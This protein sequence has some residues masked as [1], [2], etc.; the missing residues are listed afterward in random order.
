[1]D[2]KALFK[3][4]IL[5]FQETPLPE[6]VPRDLAVPQDSQKVITVYGPRRAG[7]TFFMYGLIDRLTQRVEKS[8]IIYFNLE[9]ERLLPLDV[10]EMHLLIDAYFEL[11]P[12]HREGPVYLF[13]DE[14]Q[15]V[16]GWEVFIRRLH[17]SRR[18]RIFLTGSS[19]NLLSREIAT[20]LRGRT[21]AYQLTP[22]SF[23]EYLRF[24]EIPFDPKTIRY[25]ENRFS[26]IRALEDYLEWGGYPE[27][28][29]SDD[30]IALDILQN[31]FEMIVYR[32]IADRFSL[33]NSATL[34]NLL[35]Y[36]LTNVS[37][38]F[39]VNRY[40]GSLEPGMG[41][42]RETIQEYLS[43]ILETDII[44]LVPRFTFSLK[45]QEKNP[46]KVYAIDNGLR[47]ATAFVFSQDVGRLAENLVFQEL[48]RSGF[49]IYYWK[50]KQEV[51]FIARRRNETWAVNVSYGDEI[52]AREI[53][54]FQDLTASNIKPDRRLLIT[55]HAEGAE[56]NVEMAPLW[57]WL[58]EKK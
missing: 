51:D 38:L 13:L 54:G 42:A 53:T 55:K 19:A 37:N 10:K 2:K 36:L 3:R 56:G 6:M 5:E 49:E 18:F 12:E 44:A 14:I 43:C 58:I 33:R 30:E 11:F 26:V 20:S 52:P 48:S 7:K 28:V 27:V 50:G 39:S 25:S 40:Q 16:S 22:L 32:D 24:R 46:K 8:R 15:V 17:E 35:K 45:A 21:L 9:D 47:K 41:A 31:Y 29:T 1:M 57:A 34:K 23:S 4:V